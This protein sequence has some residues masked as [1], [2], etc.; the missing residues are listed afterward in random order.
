M[1]ISLAQID[2]TP[3]TL[4]VLREEAVAVDLQRRSE[5]ALKAAQRQ[6]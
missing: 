2:G 1:D 3:K 6:R 4:E 5:A